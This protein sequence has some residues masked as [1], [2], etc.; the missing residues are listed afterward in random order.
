MPKKTSSNP[1]GASSKTKV[2]KSFSQKFMGE[3]LKNNSNPDRQIKRIVEYIFHLLVIVDDINSNLAQLAH[4]GLLEGAGSK[5]LQNVKKDCISKVKGL[6]STLPEEINTNLVALLEKQDAPTEKASTTEAVDP[7]KKAMETLYKAITM[8]RWIHKFADHNTSLP[9]IKKAEKGNYTA[10]LK[11]AIVGGSHNPDNLPLIVHTKVLATGPSQQEGELPVILH[12]V[13]DEW[14]FRRYPWLKDEIPHSSYTLFSCSLDNVINGTGIVPLGGMKKIE[15]LNLVDEDLSEKDEQI[16]PA[17]LQSGARSSEKTSLAE[18][19]KAQEKAQKTVADI[20]VTEKANG[21]YAACQV[22]RMPDDRQALLFVSSKIAPLI[23]KIPECDSVEEKKQG[24]LEQ[25]KR[26]RQEGVLNPLLDF[27][28]TE[29][30]EQLSKCGQ[31]GRDL[32]NPDNPF[33][34]GGMCVGEA[35]QGDHMIPLTGSPTIRWFKQTGLDASVSIHSELV[36]FSDVGLPTVKH[37]AISTEQLAEKEKE[38]RSSK[39][40][41]GFV[42]YYKVDGKVRQIKYKAIPYIILRALREFL[43]GKRGKERFAFSWG[44]SSTA[45]VLSSAD[46]PGHVAQVID[47]FLD[48]HPHL[49]A[50]RKNAEF[51]SIVEENIEEYKRDFPPFIQFLLDRGY[52]EGDLGYGNGFGIGQLYKDFVEEAGVTQVAE[53]TPVPKY[54]QGLIIALSGPPGVGKDSVAEKL[55]EDDYWKGNKPMILSKDRAAETLRG[56][57]NYS[58]CLDEK[59]KTKKRFAWLEQEIKKAVN[60][61]RP[62]IATTCNGSPQELGWIT[63]AAQKH[64]LAVMPVYPEISQKDEMTHFSAA[65]IVSVLRRRSHP[66]L[67]PF[68]GEAKKS[69]TDAF[70]QVIKRRMTSDLYTHASADGY[71]RIP[72]SDFYHKYLPTQALQYFDLPTFNVFMKKTDLSEKEVKIQDALRNVLAFVDEQKQDISI[73]TES[74]EVLLAAPE[75][76]INEIFKRNSADVLSKKLIDIIKVLKN[77]GLD[78]ENRKRVPKNNATYYG[79]FLEPKSEEKLKEAVKHGFGKSPELPAFI[80]AYIDEQVAEPDT[81]RLKKGKEEGAGR[82]SAHLTLTHANLLHRLR[83]EAFD[84]LEKMVAENS[85]NGA[86]IKLEVKK[87]CYNQGVLYA[88]N[89]RVLCQKED[90]FENVTNLLVASGMPHITLA[91]RDGINPVYALYAEQA[92]KAGG[93][94]A[95]GIKTLSLD[96]RLRLVA[97]VRTDQQDSSLSKKARGI[98]AK[99]GNSST[100][101]FFSSTA[102][103]SASA[104]AGG[105]ACTTGDQI[106]FD[107]GE[108]IAVNRIKCR[109]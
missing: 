71:G 31:D 50:L 86:V 14:T 30:I 93:A 78:Y 43:N 6:C 44:R 103:S 80:K 106:A 56:D 53:R 13:S 38:W 105:A 108:A 15:G 24:L 36:R 40:K 95:R 19:I 29:S 63:D 17:V 65:L 69:L 9:V 64:N 67:S 20:Y 101:P 88:S 33:W 54:F 10:P 91:M 109:P 79:A 89:V 84:T 49:L 22:F 58:S 70:A 35:E 1:A 96:K 75:D 32:F 62:I 39:D 59:V 85:E 98:Q 87:I 55:A 48:T 60:A 42:V 8:K 61:N 25:L 21:A 52:F 2:E 27:I 74:L 28:A 92:R 83:P 72:A 46:R 5:A 7:Q 37:Y 77:Q 16:I 57:P 47:E 94:R 26:R 107:S 104:Q 100:V 102:Q 18:I 81:K 3:F 97:A 23:L 76:Q 73:S 68:T 66:T 41:E 90:H 34:N 82:R 4:A 51:A 99:A 11:I 45:A 12:D